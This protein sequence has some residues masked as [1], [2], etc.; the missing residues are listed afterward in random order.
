MKDKIKE[1]FINLGA[2]VCGVANIE[3]F[4]DAPKGFNPL[5]IYADCKSVIVFAKKI[6]NGLADVSP[7][8]IYQ[9]FNSIGP[10]ELDRIAYLASNEIEKMFN[11]IVVPIP[12]DSPYDY[13]NEDKLEG[14]GLIS[15]KHAAV[16]AGIGVLGKS[17]ILLNKQYG[18]MLNIGAVLTNLD[19][20]SDAPSENI[21]I[22]KCRICIENCPVNA[23]SES[24][25][26]QSLCRKNA[27][28]KNNKGFSIVNCNKCRT[29][30][31]M[32]FGKK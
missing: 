27:Y 3:L 1:I 2:E 32:R 24:G 5:D 20:Q 21:C 4:T 7:R 28:G 31:P 29:L 9:H 16:N 15:M 19:L 26:N 30:C 18:N 23:I 6:P 11:A 25:V 14:R 12:S 17:T 13:W 22:N 8:I 10:V